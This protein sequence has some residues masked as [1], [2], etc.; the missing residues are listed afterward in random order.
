MCGSSQI[1]TNTSQGQKVG[2][3]NQILSVNSKFWKIHGSFSAL[4]IRSECACVGV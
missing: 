2:I 4:A 1:I 3:L